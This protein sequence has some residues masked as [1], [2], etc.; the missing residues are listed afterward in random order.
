MY[1]CM[2]VCARMF[3]DASVCKDVY[4]CVYCCD[5]YFYTCV[6]M[7]ANV[8]TF[9]HR[10][11]CACLYVG[12]LERGGDTFVASLGFIHLVGFDNKTHR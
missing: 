5:V 11:V 8:C 3:V 4:E 6:C 10:N 2:C 7:R 9:V 1:E 12:A